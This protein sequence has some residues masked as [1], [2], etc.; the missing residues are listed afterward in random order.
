MTHDQFLVARLMALADEYANDDALASAQGFVHRPSCYRAAL[1]SALQSALSAQPAPTKTYCC[2][3]K[4]AD[5]GHDDDCPTKAKAATTMPCDVCNALIQ[6][7]NYTHYDAAYLEA[8]Q[9]RAKILHAQLKVEGDPA[10]TEQAQPVAYVPR[11]IADG[12][13]CIV[14]EFRWQEVEERPFDIADPH[15]E[16]CPI[17]ATPPT[18]QPAEQTHR[19]CPSHCCPIHGCKYGHD[20][21]PVVNGVVK[22]TYPNN[23]GCEYC[24]REPA[25]QATQSAPEGWQLVPVN[26]DPSGDDPDAERVSDAWLAA[27]D[28]FNSEIPPR[29]SGFAKWQARMKAAMTVLALELPPPAAPPQDAGTAATGDGSE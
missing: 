24:E 29:I 25:E 17:Y 28:A 27:L 12:E 9:A 10:P 7:R 3:G 5:A 22:P 18:A 8:A 4:Y 19:S 26:Y 14:G 21:C 13:H 15:W 6:P 20:D 16:C 1:E 23:N 2:Y 11:A